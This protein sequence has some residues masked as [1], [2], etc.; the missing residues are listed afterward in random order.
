[1][2]ILALTTKERQEIAMILHRQFYFL[3]CYHLPLLVLHL[4][5]FVPDW[6]KC[7][8]HGKIPQSWLIS[9]LAGEIDGTFM[10]AKC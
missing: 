2:P 5:N 7:Y 6:H 1:M 4:D 3:A 8:P 9:H 10:N